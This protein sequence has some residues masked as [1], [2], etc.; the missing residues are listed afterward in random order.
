MCSAMC[1]CV[2]RNFGQQWEELNRLFSC[3]IQEVDTLSSD[4]KWQP[5]LR[6]RR[7]INI[8]R[9]FSS[10]KVAP[11]TH[12]TS[13]KSHAGNLKTPRK[14]P[15]QNKH[16]FNILFQMH[17]YKISICFEAKTF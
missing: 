7:E 2:A 11:Y 12:H 8:V 16:G 14:N 6:T 10:I 1:S 3:G 9:G 17:N 15:V 4:S 5:L 13:K